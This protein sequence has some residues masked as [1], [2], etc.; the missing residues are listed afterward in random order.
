MSIAD[1]WLPIL[2]SAVLAWIAS[3]LIWTVLPWHKKDYAKTSDEEGA[4]AALQG[5]APGLYNVPHVTDMKEMQSEAMQQK[6]NDGPVAFI[7]VLPN[8][9][10]NMGR[11]MGLSFVYNLV[12]GVLVAYIV[13]RTTAAD[14]SYLETFRVAGTTAWIAYG[15]GVIPD[16]IWFGRPWSSSGKHLFDAL[17]YGLLTGGAFGWLA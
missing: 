8:G 4:R 3:A 5:L 15:V 1:L 11:N 9:I 14:A 6:F 2:V 10:P 13:S 17:I 12:V 16:S 7:T